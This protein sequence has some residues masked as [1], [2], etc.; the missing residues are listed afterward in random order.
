MVS[1]ERVPVADIVAEHMDL[2]SVEEAH[3]SQPESSQQPHLPQ[4]EFQSFPTLPPLSTQYNST[5]SKVYI[6]TLSQEH[7]F[8]LSFY[9]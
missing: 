2:Q 4:P 3:Y 9:S 5:P 6:S 7:T 8:F 1:V